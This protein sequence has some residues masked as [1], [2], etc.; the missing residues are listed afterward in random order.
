MPALRR[1]RF[2][3]LQPF[4]KTLSSM[5]LQCGNRRLDL[6]TPIVMGILNVTP[7]SFSDGGRFV[8][9][10]DA[11]ARGLTMVEEGVGII[12][13]GG[14]S[15]RPGAREV[16][17]DE[18][19]RRVVPLVEALAARTDIPVSVDTSKPGVMRAALSAGATF[20]NDVR[21]LRED[22]ALEAAASSDAAICLM[23]M[24]GE[25]RTMQLEPSYT[26]VLVEVRQF[27]QERIAACVAAGI[28]TDRLALDPGIGFG[29]RIEHN[30]K[31]LASLP[32]L[33]ELRRPLLIGVSRKSMFATLL[34][35]AV[36]ERLPGSLA[37][38]VASILAGA[39]IVRTHDVAETV[40]AVKIAAALRTSGY[41][42]TRDNEG[43]RL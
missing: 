8:T 36:N 34:G 43:E 5:F 28:S 1:H 39:S 13:V 21:A 42:I 17:E 31:L 22:G 35:R 38:A 14:E 40:D 4:L 7:D 30:V 15:T 10:N 6:Y 26:D 19:I 24:Q 37:V 27:L 33:L 9:F 41:R 25:P 11:L 20:I 29:K 18:E 2:F 16:P 12:D 3:W 32:E 23:H